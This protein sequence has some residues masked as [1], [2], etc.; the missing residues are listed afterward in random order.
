MLLQPR[1]DEI[2]PTDAGFNAA[3]QL[4][5]NSLLGAAG[6]QL[7]NYQSIPTRLISAVLA[8][9]ADCTELVQLERLPDSSIRCFETHQLLYLRGDHRSKN[10]RAWD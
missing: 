8:L 5:A 6:R 1:V 3:M 2:G 4:H 10:E 7:R 9:G